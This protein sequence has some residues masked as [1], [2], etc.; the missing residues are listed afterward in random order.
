MEYFLERRLALTT[1]YKAVQNLVSASNLEFDLDS[2]STNIMIGTFG[3]K[4]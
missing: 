3:P 4:S 1:I 2:K